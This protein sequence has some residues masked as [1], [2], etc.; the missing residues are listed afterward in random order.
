MELK[1]LYKRLLDLGYKPIQIYQLLYIYDY[2][3]ENN[4]LEKFDELLS[5]I[6]KE[7]WYDELDAIRYAITNSIPYNLLIEKNSSA[8]CMKAIVEFLISAKLTNNFDEYYIVA[9]FM[10][11]HH[12]SSKRIMSLK[13]FIEQKPMSPND[14]LKLCEY[15][16]RYDLYFWMVLEDFYKLYIC[17]TIEDFWNYLNNY[18][19]I[20]ILN[21]LAK[22]E[23]S[24]EADIV[25][26]DFKDDI[27]MYL[28]EKRS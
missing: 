16:N 27:D 19:T 21:A 26:L 10:Y 5:K 7:Y 15:I 3:K 20:N 22:N 13:K 1:I 8:D 28:Y 11:S 18:N 14:L 24:V 25:Y 17:C 12:F 6:S 9:D 2:Y 23:R 4:T